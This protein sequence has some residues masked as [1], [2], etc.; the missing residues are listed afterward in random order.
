MPNNGVNSTIHGGGYHH[1]AIRAIDYDETL[2]FYID[3]LGF[4]RRYGWGADGRSK[5][6]KDSRAALLDS[7]DGNYLE[8][9]AGGS[10]TLWAE[11]P[12]GAFLHIAFRTTDIKAATER[13][14]A[15]GATITTEPKSVV[16]PNADEPAQTLWV[17]FFRGPSGEIVE[18][19]QNDEL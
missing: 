9:F 3:G 10:G 1:V 7:G 13:A 4:T 2:K 6:E 17:A 18:F 8:V 19:F 15:A 16:P 14:R 11:V 5:G 12:D